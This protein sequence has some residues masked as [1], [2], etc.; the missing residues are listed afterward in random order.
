VSTST[1]TLGRVSTAEAIVQLIKAQILDGK[2]P[3]GTRLREVELAELHDVSRQSLRAAFVD[4]G[5]LG[6]VVQRPHKGVWV[7]DLLPEDIEDLYRVRYVIESEAVRYVTATPST[8]DRLKRCLDR[9]ERVSPSAG[10][11]EVI[12]ADW[13]FHREAVT[14]V[15]SLRL[16]R[17]H[18]MLEGETSLSF[19]RSEF[20]G[21]IG[22]VA[23]VHRELLQAILTGDCA[24][25]LEALWD[26]L[27][28]SKRLVLKARSAGSAVQ[29]P[30]ERPSDAAAPAP[31][32]P[33]PAAELRA[34]PRQLERLWSVFGRGD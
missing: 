15:G 2:L 34:E 33:A 6:L 8:W 32:A 10:W 24:H 11:S 16:I 20:D 13:S 21:D 29:Q 4:L 22:T 31:R 12:D 25:A 14:C 18:D 7:R 3:P 9:L 1:Q 30:V 5:R 26:H 28:T 27:E 17:A 19:M 23:D